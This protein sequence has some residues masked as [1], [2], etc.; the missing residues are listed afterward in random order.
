[1]NELGAVKLERD[2]AGIVSAAAKGGRYEL[3]DLFARSVQMTLIMNMEEDE[4]EEISKMNGP[5][6]ERETGV[7]WK[8]DADERKRARG[9]VKDRS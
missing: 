2:V 7:S 5:Q 9:V 1:V 8:L 6:L 4:W 3:R